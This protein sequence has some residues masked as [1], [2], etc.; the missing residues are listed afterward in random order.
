MTEIGFGTA[1]LAELPGTYGYSVDEAMAHA[2]LHAIFRAPV[3]LMNTSR[4]YGFGC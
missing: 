2:T 3:N 4:N 1:P